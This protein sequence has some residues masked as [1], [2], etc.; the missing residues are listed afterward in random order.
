[1]DT[2]AAIATGS[3]V[4]AIGIVRGLRAGGAP[5]YGP[6]LCALGRQTDERAR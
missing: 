5:A 2:I 6:R 4:S 1:M 3:Q